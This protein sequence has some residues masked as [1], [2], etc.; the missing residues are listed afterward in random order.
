MSVDIH[1]TTVNEAEKMI[2]TVCQNPDYSGFSA[3]PDG[4][5]GTSTLTKQTIATSLKMSSVNGVPYTDSDFWFVQWDFEVDQPG[6]VQA[7]FAFLRVDAGGNPIPGVFSL[8]SVDA[9]WNAAG[10]ASG[11]T[12]GSFCI[13]EMQR[14]RSPFPASDGTGP[15][16]P[17]AVQQLTYGGDML[18]DAVRVLG[19]NWEEV[20]TTNQ[21]N[22]QGNLYQGAWESN[23]EIQSGYTDFTPVGSAST[24]FQTLNA[25][26]AFGPPGTSASLIK[27][28][29][30][31]V[32]AAKEGS[33]T[34]NRLDLENNKPTFAS[35]Y[36][37]KVYICDH[38]PNLAALPSIAN[39]VLMVVTNANYL[40]IFVAAGT[41][42]NNLSTQVRNRAWPTKVQM[43]TM[44]LSGLNAAFSANVRRTMTTQC[45]VG[46]QSDF[47]AFAK[48]NW[49]QSDPMILS[50]L[51]NAMDATQMFSKSD[52]NFNGK[53]AKKM[54]ENFKK[55][56]TIAR[57]IANIGKTALKIAN[58]A[59]GMA[60]ERGLAKAKAIK[61]QANNLKDKATK[62]SVDEIHNE[63]SKMRE[64]MKTLAI[65][66]PSVNGSSKKM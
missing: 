35:G 3:L 5:K 26:T 59:A 18:H 38:V 46:P 6:Q 40:N 30:N 49:T 47:I 62:G 50:E 41:A 24:T 61:T 10:Y 42:T 66:G 17:R 39:K 43:N 52:E 9:G 37:N 36:L 51:Q 28:P 64:K 45:F 20:D 23:Q 21:L 29:E 25:D 13:Y 55:V 15:Y 56:S 53:F 54:K 48:T 11:I 19:S 22:Q 57:P 4:V 12:C 8:A 65:K 63:L 33:F 34:M 60:L 2:D 44:I 14:G 27:M 1:K 32:G 16:T 58:P 31:R 7:L